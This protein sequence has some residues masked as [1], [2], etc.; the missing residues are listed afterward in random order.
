MTH[1]IVRVKIKS[2]G[3]IKI[4]EV[5]E[6]YKERFIKAEQFMEY[7]DEKGEISKKTQSFSFELSLLKE[8]RAFNYIF[9]S[10]HCPFV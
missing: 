10:L 2:T 1:E 8:N 7:V 5:P 4:E 9:S 3:A 6:A